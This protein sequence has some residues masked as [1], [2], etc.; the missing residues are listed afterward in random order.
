MS[1]Q[2]TVI[3]NKFTFQV[4]DDDLFHRPKGYDYWGDHFSN[5]EP[6]VFD[7]YDKF[8]NKDKDFLDIGAWIGPNTLYGSILSRSVVSI[9]PDPVAFLFLEKNIEAN[10]IKN[11][12]LINKAFTSKSEV[13]IDKNVELD[14]S[15]TRVLECDIYGKESVAGI[16]METL[17]SIGDYSLMK[18]DIE[19]YESVVI[20]DFEETLIEANIPMILSFHTSFNPLKE[21]GHK[22]LLDSLGKIYKKAFWEFENPIDIKDIP[23]GFGCFLFI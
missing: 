2:I 1:K 14:D 15:M 10:K 12:S 16:D 21:V 11:V 20:P 23:M 19:G 18:I 8:L 6:F 3:K 7:T 4:I 13:K 17:L 5:S 22:K 9:E